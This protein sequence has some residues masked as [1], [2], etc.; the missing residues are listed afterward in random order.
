[1][2]MCVCR[3]GK[4]PSRVSQQRC[5]VRVRGRVLRVVHDVHAVVAAEEAMAMAL[6][7]AKA[8]RDAAAMVKEEEFPTE[9]DLLRLERAR[10]SDMEQS[11]RMEYDAESALL[12]AEQGYLQ[13]LESLLG[14]VS[15]LLREADV[16]NSG[17]ESSSLS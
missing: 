13:E 4:V 3:I 6:A 14:G 5:R 10:L 17:N 16:P 2:C 8:A 7:A 12:Q 9:F 1:M 11:F 15:N